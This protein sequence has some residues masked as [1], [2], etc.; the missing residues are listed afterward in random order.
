MASCS[1]CCRD[2]VWVTVSASGKRMPIDP[3]PRLD[4]NLRFLASRAP[5]GTRLVEYVTPAELA[6]ASSGLRFV[7]HFATCPDAASHR[8]PLQQELAL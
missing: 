4:G 1:S 5:D 6:D 2:V 7:S 3:A 8:K